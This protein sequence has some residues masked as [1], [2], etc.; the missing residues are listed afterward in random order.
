MELA[1]LP[2]DVLLS[3]IIVRLPPSS[4]SALSQTCKLFNSIC[5]D[6]NLWREKCRAD[7]NLPPS[8]YGRFEWSTLYRLL[9]DPVVLTWGENDGRLMQTG[10]KSFGSNIEE[11][12][13]VE[14]LR[15]KKIVQLSGSGWGFHALSSDGKVYAWGRLKDHAQNILQ[16]EV[17][18]LNHTFTSISCGRSHAL[19][20]TDRGQVYW[21][22]DIHKPRLIM[23]GDIVSAVSG[24]TSGVILLRDGSVRYYSDLTRQPAEHPNIN[25]SL[26]SLCLSTGTTTTDDDRFVQV[27]AG[28][29]LG[30]ALSSS[31]QLWDLIGRKRL[32]KFENANAEHPLTHLTA[33]FQKF[34]VYNEAGDVLIGSSR[35]IT[36]PQVIKGLQKE[37]V[38]Q[39]S[40]GDWHS[41]ALNDQGQVLAWGGWQNGARGFK[42]NGKKD[43]VE[44]PHPVEGDLKGMFAFQISFAGWHSAALAV[45]M[46]IDAF[47]EMIK[48]RKLDVRDEEE[49]EQ[50]RPRR[51]LRRGPFL[52]GR[53]GRSMGLPVQP[54][55]KI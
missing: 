13:V 45:P 15:G 37:G 8:L 55:N 28:E 9:N 53:R 52:P 10:D 30:L 51:N 19:A 23:E 18:P 47:E 46:S 6:H 25:E 33:S 43:N 50:E 42:L 11:P 32:T 44:E 41:G 24:W 4:I 5:K 14:G 1:D 12:K 27:A 35:D 16:A 31:G 7:Y 29:G 49:P 48:K 34:A 3:E 39:V 54:P 21:W 38:V 17:V 22:N 20:L 2:D 40:F 36:E 26:H